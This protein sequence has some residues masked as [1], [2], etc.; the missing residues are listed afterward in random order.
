MIE[1]KTYYFYSKNDTKKEAISKVIALNYEDALYHFS[2]KKQ[3][4]ADL[5]SSLYNIEVYE[6]RLK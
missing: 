4:E 6:D 5:F 3:M 2:S 1:Y